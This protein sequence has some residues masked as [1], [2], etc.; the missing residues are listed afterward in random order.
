MAGPDD[1]LRPAAKKAPRPVAI[2]TLVWF[3]RAG[4]SIAHS[5]DRG[6]AFQPEAHPIA[7]IRHFPAILIHYAHIQDRRRRSIRW[8][9]ATEGV[10]TSR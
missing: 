9:T 2:G 10:N 7:C 1:H 3:M 6:V 5:D 4:V 8:Q